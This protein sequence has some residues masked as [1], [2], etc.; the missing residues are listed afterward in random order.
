VRRDTERV[1]QAAGDHFPG[2]AEAVEPE[3]ESLPLRSPAA[4]GAERRGEVKDARGGRC[5]LVAMDGQQ[6]PG[7]DRKIV[8]A[9]AEAAGRSQ[10]RL[11]VGDAPVGADPEPRERFRG[12]RIGV[13]EAVGVSQSP[14]LLERGFDP[15]D[16]RSSPATVRRPSGSNA[17]AIQ[18]PSS[19]AAV[20]TSVASKP[21]AAQSRGGRPGAAGVC[22]H[23]S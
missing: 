8:A 9:V 4:A 18:L 6:M 17:M 21:S 13:Q 15:L 2:A 12:V 22:C 3:Q 20:R 5:H 1:P 19:A 23:C 16:L 7:L 10:Q 14:A 11:D